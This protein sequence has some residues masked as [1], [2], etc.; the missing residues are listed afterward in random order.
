VQLYE[1]LRATSGRAVSPYS[2]HTA[3]LKVGSYTGARRPGPAIDIT[4]DQLADNISKAI[5]K[6]VVATDSANSV[7]HG[8]PV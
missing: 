7:Y 3:L 8:R 1:R 5:G 2:L 6:R 4:D